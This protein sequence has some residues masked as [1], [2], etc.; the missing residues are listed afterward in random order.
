MMMRIARFREKKE[1]EKGWKM[2]EKTAIVQR[3]SGEM[4][5][6]IQMKGRTA[7]TRVWTVWGRI[8]NEKKQMK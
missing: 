6:Y 1:L 4:Y 5:A 2:R 3:K 7:H 8:V